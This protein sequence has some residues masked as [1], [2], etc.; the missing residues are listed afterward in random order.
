MGK[1]GLLL[2]VVIPLGITPFSRDPVGGLLLSVVIPLGITPF[3]RDP[4][5]DYSFQS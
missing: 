4:V 2:S 1:G 3:S 5:G